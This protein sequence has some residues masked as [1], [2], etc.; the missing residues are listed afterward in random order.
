MNTGLER[1]KVFITGASRGIGRKVKETFEQC[2]SIVTAP[3]RAQLDLSDREKI[4]DYLDANEDLYPDIFDMIKTDKKVE[5]NRI[6]F[7]MPNRKSHLIVYPMDIDKRL[8][9]MFLDYI[10]ETHEYYSN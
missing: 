5:G 6:S 4:C 2:G 9:T 8:E 3:G 7:V 10:G 1:R